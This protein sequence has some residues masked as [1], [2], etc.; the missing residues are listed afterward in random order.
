M[1]VILKCLSLA[2]LLLTIVPAILVSR[3]NLE[4]ES[5]YSLMIVGMVVWFIA[6]PFWMQEKP[7]EGV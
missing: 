2:G 6:T 7:D 3:G 1:K 5:H 4:I